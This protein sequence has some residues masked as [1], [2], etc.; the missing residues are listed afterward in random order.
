[1]TRQ[2]VRARVVIHGKVQ[3][4]FFRA[5]TQNE[6]LCTEIYGWVKNRR[7]GTV[8]AVFE[9]DETS[10]KAMLAWCW[11]GSAH[12]RVEQVDTQWEPYTGE[13]SRFDITR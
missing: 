13:F 4:V 8:E 11:K 12:S 10:V 1:M 7:D 9:G 6:A 5:E 3:G 2:H